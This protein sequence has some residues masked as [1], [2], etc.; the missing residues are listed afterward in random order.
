MSLQKKNPPLSLM[1][2]HSAMLAKVAT[3]PALRGRY[4]R[5]HGERAFTAA[6]VLEDA[7]LLL[8][9]RDST[10]GCHSVA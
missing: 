10:V 1:S 8:Y 2:F 5:V 4:G 7:A 3:F 6:V 9:I